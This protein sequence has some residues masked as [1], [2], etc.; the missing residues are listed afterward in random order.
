[1]ER[2][3]PSVRATGKPYLMPREAMRR[4]HAA[5]IEAPPPVQAPWI[6]AISGT[7]HF[8]IAFITRSMR[9]S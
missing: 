9:A 7:R 8:S 6:A 2:Q 4:S 1:M 3:L 5:A